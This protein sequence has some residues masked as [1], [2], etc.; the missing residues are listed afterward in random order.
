MMGSPNSM[1]LFVLI[2]VAA[3]ALIPVVNKIWRELVDFLSI[4][5]GAALFLLAV[6]FIAPL[7]IYGSLVVNLADLLPFA[8]TFFLDGLSLLLLIVVN[9]VAL[10]VLIFSIEYMK[11]YGDKAKYYALFLL[12]L[13]GMNGV[14]LAHD[15]FGLYVFLEVAACSS[16]ALVAFGLEH[17]E[18]EAAFKYLVLAAAASALILLGIALVYAR[19]GS[20]DMKLVS[21][22]MG[23]ALYRGDKGV[24]F[25]VLLFVTGFG[26][27]MAMVPFHAWLP[28]AHPSAPAPISAMLSGVLIKASG[29]YALMRILYNVLGIQNLPQ[30]GY[31]IL[32]L[33]ILTIVIASL[34]AL[35]QN[36]F[37]RLLAYSSISQ[38]G[39]ILLGFGAGTPLAL[40]GAL[41]HLMNHA[42]FKSLLFLVSGATQQATG[43]RDLDKMGGLARKLPVTAATSVFGSL[44]IAGVPP[45]NGFFSKAVIIVGLVSAA[46]L[47]GNPVYYWAAGVAIGF[48]L[49]T[50]G[51][52]LKV[53]R[54]AFFGKLNEAY[55]N[56][57]EVGFAM[58][59]P[60]ILLAAL[61]V[62]LGVGYP[63][64]YENLLNPAAGVLASLMVR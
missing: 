64:L 61:C 58:A 2:P 47:S 4:V 13:A 16:Y 20:L 36:D 6:S 56:V 39:Y 26:L 55:A 44:A 57:R 10:L 1:L 32:G 14:V 42:T 60:M 62:A 50:L 59:L 51:Y 30:V 25:I 48:S 23:M 63:W 46:Q 41:Y 18:L 40:V 12:M 45:F 17:D 15:L 9:G 35:V 29:V 53:Q 38:I 8:Q 31:T 37:K 21:E 22:A 28:D 5:A 27:K 52:F 43:T 49:L 11:H 33:G 7:R 24:L 54:K 3:A 34:L 19:T